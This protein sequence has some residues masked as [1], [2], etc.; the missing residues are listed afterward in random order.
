MKRRV[1][2]SAS[3]GPRARSS[4]RRGDRRRG[5]VIGS[6]GNRGGPPIAAI[7]K[8][9]S[10]DSLRPLFIGLATDTEQAIDR[11]RRYV[12]LLLE[13]NR[14]VSNLISRNDET[15]ILERHLR[16]S[17]EPAR[18]M[19]ESGALR[20]VDFGSG[21]G[22]PAIPLAIAGVGQHW[23]LVESRRPKTLFMR[24]VLLEISLDRNAVVH[25]RLEELVARVEYRA[26]FDAF[27]SRATLRLGPTLDLAAPLV[28]AG[29]HAF[30]WKGSRREDEMRRD[31]NWSQFWDFEGSM[32][33]GKDGGEIS[34][35]IRK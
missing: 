3:S 21:A 1:G 7:L 4:P 2:A 9:Q 22:L 29:G 13:W 26:A 32:K 24:K 10:W 23:T 35:F 8:S 34:K 14:Q 28:H 15:R 12:A 20:W 6:A 5:P 18:W 25:S 30:L 33:A 31:T 11:L 16:E 27:T 17:L 19:A